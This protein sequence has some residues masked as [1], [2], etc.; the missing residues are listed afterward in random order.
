M[1]ILLFA[2]GLF[3]L[4]LVVCGWR[5]TLINLAICFFVQVVFNGYFEVFSEKHLFIEK[6]VLGAPFI[7]VN[8]HGYI[9]ERAFFFKRIFDHDFSQ[10]W[11]FLPRTL[12]YDSRFHIILMIC[13]AL[14]PIY[15]AFK[16]WYR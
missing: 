5:R 3:T 15:F 2:P 13:Q 14:C 12:F 6:L 9:V 10:N 4:Y 1:N 16:V 8:A 7:Y 11:R